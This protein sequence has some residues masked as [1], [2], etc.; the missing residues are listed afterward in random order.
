[1]IADRSPRP[2]RMLAGFAWLGATAAAAMFFV[3]GTNWQLGVLLLIIANLALGSSL[4]IYDSLLVRIASPD[5]RARVSS[6]GWGFG[7]RG[8]G[9]LLALNLGLGQFH[10]SLALDTKL[11]TRISLPAARL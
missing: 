11:S 10:T 3:A 7:Y 9:I 4:V 5:D 1:G 2:T 8:G 6:K